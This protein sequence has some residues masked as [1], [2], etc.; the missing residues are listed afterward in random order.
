MKHNLRFVLRCLMKI[1][2]RGVNRNVC[3]C[4]YLLMDRREKEA[5]VV[6]VI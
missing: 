1:Q 2:C 6:K 3:N 5:F 4:E